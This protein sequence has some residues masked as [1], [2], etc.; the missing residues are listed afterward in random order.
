MTGKSPS[1]PEPGSGLDA[2]LVRTA[3]VEAIR[4]CGKS[5]AQLADEMSLLTGTEVTVRRLNAFTAAS[6]EDYR[7]PAEL[8]RA[9]CFATGSFLLLRRLVEQSGF[10]MITLAERDLLNLGRECLKRDRS[11]KKVSMLKRRLEGFDL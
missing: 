7:F 1:S 10:S 4:A 6:R 5:R 9:F 3:L 2:S 11:T 8:L